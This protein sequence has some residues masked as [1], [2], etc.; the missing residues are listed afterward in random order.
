MCEMDAIFLHKM[1]ASDTYNVELKQINQLELRHE[2]ITVDRH[3]E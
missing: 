1:D 3:D 2:V